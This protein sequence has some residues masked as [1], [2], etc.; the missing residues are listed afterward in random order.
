[1]VV[2]MVTV[3]VMA[4]LTVAMAHLT[5]MVAALVVMVPHTDMAADLVATVHHTERLHPAAMAPL[6]E[7]LAR[8]HHLRN[9]VKPCSKN[10][11]ERNLPFGFR[12]FIPGPV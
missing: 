3:R 2:E 4:I 8:T 11:S 12:S 9:N 1:M 5:V 10:T 7:H 6:T